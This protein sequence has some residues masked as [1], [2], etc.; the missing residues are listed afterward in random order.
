MREINQAVH[1]SMRNNAEACDLALYA[2]DHK[3]SI[4]NID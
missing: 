3:M 1:V 2:V 4:L